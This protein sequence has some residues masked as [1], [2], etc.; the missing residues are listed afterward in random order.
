MTIDIETKAPLLES[1]YLKLEQDGWNFKQCRSLCFV[2][3]DPYSLPFL[4]PDRMKRMRLSSSISRS[5]SLNS[6]DSSLSQ[7]PSNSTFRDD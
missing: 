4:Q 5:S 2:A 7:S 6:S 3:S 1:F